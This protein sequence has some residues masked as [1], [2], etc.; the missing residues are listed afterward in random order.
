MT[1][2][3]WVG[4]M[5]QNRLWTR[6]I[7][8][9]WMNLSW[10]QLRW[11]KVNTNV[12]IL[13]AGNSSM[14]C[15]VLCIP[16]TT[17][18]S[19]SSFSVGSKVLSKYMSRLLRIIVFLFPLKKKPHNKEF[20]KPVTKKKEFNKQSTFQKDNCKLFFTMINS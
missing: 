20:N 18:S 9:L 8:W 13:G 7:M 2:I 10:V 5:I 12:D 17:M 6:T 1:M 15:D 14:A 11:W 19:E 16:I 3:T 4:M